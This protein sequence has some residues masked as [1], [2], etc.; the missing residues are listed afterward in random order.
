MK[1]SNAPP[2]IFEYTSYRSYL[3]DVYQSRKSGRSSFSFRLFS[4]LA[5]FSSP[6]FMKLVIDGKRNLSSESIEKI[7]SALRL[8]TDQ[9]EFFRHLVF[10]NQSE[11]AQ[12]RRHWAE[13]L[14]QSRFY[15]KAQPLKHALHSYYSSWYFVAVRELIATPDFREDCAWIAQRLRPEIT[16]SEAR[17]ALDV[18]VQLGLARRDEQ[19][20]LVQSE[21]LVTTGDEIASIAVG[22]FHREM[23]RKA[24]EAIERFPAAKREV[25]GVTLGVSEES[26]LQIKTLLQRFRKDLM[27]IAARETAP[28][29]VLQV[30]LQMFPLTEAEEKG[31]RTSEPPKLEPKEAA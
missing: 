16:S 12:E 9:A 15:R 22:E 17:K 2:P 31:N 28:T 6:N 1:T 21:S 7:I 29:E 27:E 26:K 8:D 25:S 11:T 20:R 18:L 19:G 3:S 5:G 4:R 14:F 13:S 30:N 24:S 23:L 10:L